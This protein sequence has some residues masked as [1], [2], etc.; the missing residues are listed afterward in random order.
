MGLPATS[1]RFRRLR[2]CSRSSRIKKAKPLF[3]TSGIR[4]NGLGCVS[5]FG[6]PAI[7]NGQSK[8][9]L[10]ESGTEPVQWIIS[11]VVKEAPATGKASVFGSPFSGTP[12]QFDDFVV[13][14]V[15]K[16]S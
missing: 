2:S 13:S 12:I 6:K 3:L 15:K 10:A 9:S 7:S 14:A 5:R 8:Q 11:V 1:C 16:Q 4:S